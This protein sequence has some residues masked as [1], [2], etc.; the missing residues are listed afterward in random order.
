MV[1]G[2]QHKD[3]SCATV[4]P[5]ASTQLAGRASYRLRI[6]ISGS[7]CVGEAVIVSGACWAARACTPTQ[8]LCVVAGYNCPHT[9]SLTPTLLLVPH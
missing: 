3:Y 7:E 5:Q 9:L 2:G 4:N 6:S 8:E 1:F